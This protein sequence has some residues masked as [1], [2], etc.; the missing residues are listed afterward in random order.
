MA[1]LYRTLK[2]SWKVPPMRIPH[3]RVG[4]FWCCIRVVGWD[5]DSQCLFTPL[6]TSLSTSLSTLLSASRSTYVD[7][8]SG[9]FRKWRYNPVAIVALGKFSDNSTK[10]FV[11]RLVYPASNQKF[12]CIVVPADSLIFRAIRKQGDQ[13]GGSVVLRLHLYTDHYPMLNPHR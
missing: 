8:R 9:L 1:R 12:L 10:G 11:S 5:Q 13:P 4:S 3:L 6:S 2:S 7:H